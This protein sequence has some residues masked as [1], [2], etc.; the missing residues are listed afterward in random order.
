MKCVESQQDVARVYSLQHH[1]RY[2]VMLTAIP[3]QKCQDTGCTLPP[4]STS[5]SK[6]AGHMSNLTPQ[7][8]Q[9]SDPVTFWEQSFQIPAARQATLLG[10]LWNEPNPCPRNIHTYAEPHFTIPWQYLP[11]LDH[12]AGK[13]AAL[14]PP[15]PIHYWGDGTF[16]DANTCMIMIGNL[17]KET[18]A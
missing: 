5:L 12:K 14:P 8:A 4:P 1:V 18:T 11:R 3:K 2:K 16:M 15:T 9:P 17:G 7:A 6:H 13:A 10:R